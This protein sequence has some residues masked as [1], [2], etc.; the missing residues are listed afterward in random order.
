MGMMKG[1]NLKDSY[2]QLKIGMPKSQVIAMLGASNSVRARNGIEILTW[3]SREFKGILRGGTIER[4]VIIEFE[5]G[6]VIGYDG[7]NIDA[8]IW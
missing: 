3:W 1:A 7:E 6:V 5:N 2:K 4:R 8:S